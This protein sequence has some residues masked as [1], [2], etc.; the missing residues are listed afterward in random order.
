MPSGIR[1]L[2][3]LNTLEVSLVPKGAN[4]K[5]FALRKSSEDQTMDEIIQAVL[6]AELDNEAQVDKVLKAAGMSDKAQAACKSM[7]KLATGFK[8][9]MPKDLM[10]MLAK[11]SGY[12][13]GGVEKS[14]KG[15]S[16][17][18]LA[19]EVRAQ[20]EALFKASKE[21]EERALKAEAILKAERDER[22]TKEFI[23]KAADEFAHLPGTKADELGPV[24]K[25]LADSSPA[26]YEKVI[27]ILKAADSAIKA[28]E[29]LA[30]AGRASPQSGIAGTAWAQIEKMAE[31]LVQK[32]EKVFTKAQAIDEVLRSPQGKAL[33]QDYLAEHPAQTGR[34]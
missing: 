11:L 9:E 8:D 26:E 20:V 7:L 15:P 28:G 18:D 1:Q 10:K 32:G 5:R 4:K 29:V 12:E 16:L 34:K 14:D 27:G 23:T 24:L 30:Q 25:T 22:R 21:S 13:G 2:S 33:Y 3:K 19:P 6:A 17:E 31:G